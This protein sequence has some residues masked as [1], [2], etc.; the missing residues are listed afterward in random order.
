MKIRTEIKGFTEYIEVISVELEAADFLQ[1]G[2]IYYAQHH[3]FDIYKLT[4]FLVLEWVGT[5]NLYP[6]HVEV[7]RLP[8]D[9]L[10][11][12]VSRTAEPY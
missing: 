5:I 1:K 11:I 4:N 2:D 7:D 8:E 9:T 12:S 10:I 3:L 6:N